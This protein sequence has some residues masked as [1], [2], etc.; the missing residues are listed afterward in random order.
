MTQSVNQARRNEGGFTLVELAIVM[1]IIGLLIGGILKG[2]ELITNARVSAT[3]AQSKAVESGI[4]G[5]RDKYA[6]MPGDLA[7]PAAR[8]PS[9]SNKCAV[10]GNG[11]GLVQS[12]TANNFGAAEAAASDAESTVAFVQLAAAG[13]IGGVQPNT[14][15]GAT[16]LST[17]NPTT[18][19]GGGWRFGY[20][21]GGGTAVTGLVAANTG[22][23]YALSSGHYMAAVLNVNANAAAGNSPFTPIQAAAIDRK[24][25]DGTPNGGSVRATGAGAAATDCASAV[26][27]TGIYNEA[28]GTV[29][30]GL[31][32]KVQ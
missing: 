19:L 27:N 30:C 11:D 18:P 32:V 8:I 28:I 24:L 3:V 7:A 2:Q 21:N 5:F 16:A 17:T 22:A 20:S 1:I 23:G 31:I 4:S 9:C 25:D 14:A 26:D 10:V 29:N 12:T 13:F 15:A 6:G